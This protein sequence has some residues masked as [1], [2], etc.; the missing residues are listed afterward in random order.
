MKTAICDYCAKN[1][2]LNGFRVKID[3]CRGS[4]KLNDSSGS[5]HLDLH[6]CC[7]GHF[8]RWVMHPENNT[9][10][11]V[12]YFPNSISSFIPQRLVAQPQDFNPQHDDAIDNDKEK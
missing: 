10:P 9:E 6:F 1:V 3:D 2:L 7:A 11:G 5:M 12:C 4:G 8:K